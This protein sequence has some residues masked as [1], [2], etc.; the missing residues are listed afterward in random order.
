M[1]KQIKSIIKT[2]IIGL[3]IILTYDFAII[4]AIIH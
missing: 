2:S 4:Y 1:K 3:G